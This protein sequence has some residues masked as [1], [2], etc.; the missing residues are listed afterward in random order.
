MGNPRLPTAVKALRGTL[1]KAR[2]NGLEPKVVPIQVPAPPAHL[3]D[4]ERQMWERLKPMVDSLGIM[5]EADL[6]SFETLVRTRADY[7]LVRL[8]DPTDFKSI[9]EA[10]KEVRSWLCEF[11]L[12][13][14]S[15][16]KVKQIAAPAGGDDLSE[17]F[18][19]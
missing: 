3:T 2:E 12:T 10:S 1:Q 9:R 4:L 18:R 14:A 15:R 19:N 17:F 7:E 5:S 13:P 6:E 8:Q 11:G 16:A